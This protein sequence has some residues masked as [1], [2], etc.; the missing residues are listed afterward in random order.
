MPIPS[1]T[2]ITQRFI[3]SRQLLPGDWANGITDALYSAQTLVAT[4]ANQ[5]A[6][7]QINSA[8]VELTTAAAAGVRLPA[9]YPGAEVTVLNNSGA[10][11]NIYPSGT[12]QI[13]NAAN[14]YAGASTAVSLVSLQ[15]AIY[16]CVKQGYWQRFAAA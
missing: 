10:A 12:E 13:Q 5:A 2:T 7:A 14:G 9:S 15:S 16:R 6:A 1:K 11:Q 4:G 3:S 8:Q